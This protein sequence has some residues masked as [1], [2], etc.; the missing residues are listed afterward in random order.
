MRPMR[1]QLVHFP[2]HLNHRPH[3]AG[4]EVQAHHSKRV[5]LL[6]ATKATCDGRIFLSI[7]LHVVGLVYLT[8][9]DLHILVHRVWMLAE[10]RPDVWQLVRDLESCICTTKRQSL[11]NA[12]RRVWTLAEEQPE[13]WQP[14]RDPLP[15]D[16]RC[17]PSV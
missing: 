13:V 16:C 4:H 14:V 6:P 9:A 10:E 7:H 1:T 17:A 8:P 2:R 12:M 15:S 11:N 3:P 5:M